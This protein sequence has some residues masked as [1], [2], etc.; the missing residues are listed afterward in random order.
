MSVSTSGPALS[1]PRAASAIV[2][3]RLLRVTLEDGREIAVP[4][5]WFEWLARAT[6][7]QR[8]DLAII[9]GG[10]GVWWEQLEDGV[11]VPG[12]LGLPEYP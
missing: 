12:L 6:P 2:D 7:S 4:V 8:S 11:S 9:E 1:R 10:V 3:G 5:D